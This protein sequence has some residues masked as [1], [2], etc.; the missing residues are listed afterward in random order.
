MFPRLLFATLLGLAVRLAAA[1]P[2]EAEPA[3]L[4]ALRSA[5]I[6]KREVAADAF[7][8]ALPTADGRGVVIAVFDTGV[9]PAAAGLAVTSTG[10]RKLVDILDA[11]GSGDVVTSTLRRPEADGGLKGLSGRRL[12]LPEGLVNPKGEFRLGLKPAAE[13]FPAAVLKRLSDL[14]AGERAAAASR[15]QAARD[16]GPDAAARR[17]AQA[18]APEDRTRAERDLL[19]RAEALEALENTKPADETLALH[20]CLVWHDGEQWRVVVDTDEDGDLRD[21]RVLRPFGVAGEHASF[22]PVTNTSFGVQ[23]YEGGDLL[24]I[25]TVGGN[26]GTHVAAIAAAHFPGEPARDGIAPGARILSIKIGDIRTG[27]SSY[28]T[29]ELRAAALTAKHRVDIVNASWGGRSTYQ[30]GRNRNSRTYDLLVERHDILAVLSAGNNGPALGTAGSA[31]AEANRVL[32]VGAYLSPEM[33][34][35]LYQA[36][37]RHPGTAQQF[38]SRGPTKDGDLGVDVMAPGAAFASVSTEGLKG[39]EMMNGTSMA[40]PSAAGVAALVLSA[41]R[42]KGIEA[43]PARLR[44]ALIL[45]AQPLPDEDAATRGAGLIHAPRAWERL[46]ALQGV[47]AFGGFYDLE[48]DQ[49]T[50]TSRGRGLQLREVLTEPRR[51]VSVK[52]TPAWAESVAPEARV[53]F[54]ADLRLRSSA[55]WIQA[56]DY[57]HLSNGARTFGLVV[58]P[59]PVPAG[60]LGSF[61]AETVEAVLADK[62]ELGPV[63]AVPVTV[64][65]PAPAAAFRD[66]KLDTVVPLRPAETRRLFVAAPA[67]AS[68]LRLTVRHRAADTLSRRFVVQAV[69]YAAQTHIAAMETDQNLTLDPG[70]EKTFDLR[71]KPGVVVEVATTLL[72]SSVGAASL[73][74][75]LEWLGL[76]LETD[77]LVLPA[78]MTWAGLDLVPLADREVKVEAKLERAVHVF[79][80]DTTELRKMD[81]RAEHPAS[82]LTPGPVRPSF[83][84]QRFVLELKEPLSVH[85]LP[86]EDYDLGDAVG[87][88]RVTLQTES[89]EVLFD[90]SGSGSSAPGRPAVRLPKGKVTAVRDFTAPEVELLR[91]LTHTPLRLAEALK[92]SRALP[93]RANLRERL[94]GKDATELRLEAGRE[95]TLYLQDKAADDLAKHEPRPAHFA[96]TVVFRDLENRELGRRELVYVP[97][98]SPA[99]VTNQKPK[100]KPVADARTEAE[101]LA[102]TLYD[103]RLAF[104]RDHR[105][106]KEAAVQRQRAELLAALR[107]ERPEDPAPLWEAALDAA[108]AAG[109]A[110][111]FWGKARPKAE[112]PAAPSE[113][114][115]SAA[116]A[117]ADAP[118]TA[119]LAL[120]DEVVR[121]ADPDAVARQLGAPPA[122]AEL[123]GAARSKLEREKKRLTAHREILARA[124]RLRADV[125]RALGRWDE[126]WRALAEAR[127]WDPETGDRQTR[128]LEAELHEQAGHLGLALEALN[129]RLKDAPGDRKLREQRVALYE[130]L[131]WTEEAARER[132]RL[133]LHLHQKS[134]LDERF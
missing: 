77:P 60:A 109:W 101:K 129:T 12:T 53:A 84:R 75:R 51:R 67:G 79:L 38:T 35:V 62:P 61:H 89:G 93:V 26:H 92:T 82:P 127:R 88:G 112:A 78:G 46:Q 115:A 117:S 33:G 110:S 44:A 18:R 2:A 118:G 105:A 14:R 31:G 106:A 10:E 119:V 124:E 96:G 97:G 81:E 95:E 54:A 36:L 1:A 28:G 43:S 19:A 107:T 64:I 42:Q 85:V 133:A 17:A 7:L 76:G 74:V 86:P 114:P 21:E 68:R 100:P 57:V 25:V 108:Q 37:S 102:D 83:L 9:D 70:A 71:V 65:Q 34:R 126:A 111:E 131:G 66:H 63:F 27:G 23:V 56:P 87:G 29:S 41:A 99:K 104:V 130:K 69:G 55:P 98:L 58:E 8:R 5:L 120:L 128:A 116:T 125:C 13:L 103:A 122:T 132:L 32:G 80:S 123:E 30:D 22:G 24:S 20:D 11:S 113:T 94:S 6:P 91:S 45:G 47:A 73:E 121:R 90:S 50:F 16:R 59:P 3:D 4:A 40:S 15:S 49:G 48:V 134:V 39:A 52:V 72:F